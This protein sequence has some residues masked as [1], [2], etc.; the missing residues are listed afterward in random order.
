MFS[1]PNTIEPPPSRSLWQSKLNSDRDSTGVDRR[2]HHEC[3]VWISSID[4][5]FSPP[6]HAR[7]GVSKVEVEEVDGIGSEPSRAGKSVWVRLVAF[8]GAIVPHV[9][10]PGLGSA[11]VWET[12]SNEDSSE[13]SD[14]EDNRFSETE[15]EE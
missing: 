4:C 12:S 2:F 3:D 6:C 13:R 10:G 7:C 5:R 15:T 11:D 9:L 8:S 14:R 1:V